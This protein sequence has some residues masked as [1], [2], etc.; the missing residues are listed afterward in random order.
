LCSGGKVARHR[1]ETTF[2]CFH[3]ILRRHLL[4]SELGYVNGAFEIGG[5]EP[6]KV[7]GRIYALTLI[8]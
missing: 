1:V 2:R 5:N 4:D 8:R 3:L 7:I 6:L